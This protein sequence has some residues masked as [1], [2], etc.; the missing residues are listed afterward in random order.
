MSNNRVQEKWKEVGLE[1]GAGSEQETQEHQNVQEEQE[2]EQEGN[3][4][5]WESAF[6]PPGCPAIKGTRVCPRNT[7]YTMLADTQPLY[8][9]TTHFTLYVYKKHTS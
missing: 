7:L 6:G 5:H 3:Q 4:E 2:E 8:T 9:R 1:V